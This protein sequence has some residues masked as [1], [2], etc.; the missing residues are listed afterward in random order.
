MRFPFFR[1]KSKVK[2][3]NE[4]KPNGNI[5]IICAYNEEKDIGA[6]LWLIHNTKLPLQIIVIDDGSTDNT[7][8]IAEE[9]GA[10]VFRLEQNQGKTGAFFKGLK[11]ALKLN[12]KSIVFLDAD[13]TEIPTKSL[14][15]LID[16]ASYYSEK[17]ISKMLVPL[18]Y[19]GDS[20]HPTAG[21]FTGIRAFSIPAAWKVLKSRFKY[22]P[23]RFALEVFLTD[24]FKYE[25][26]DLGI[27]FR[28]E[29]AFRKPV[30]V[31]Q[32]IDIGEY[33]T[34]LNHTKRPRPL[35]AHVSG[36]IPLRRF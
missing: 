16:E 33:Y 11:E 35:R 6:T 24:L 21:K 10:R 28:T 22:I 32:G 20:K 13:M 23:R 9:N 7:A 17:R 8:K 15:R 14:Y 36:R 27:P 29:R 26:E 19:E 25:K 31:Q 30:S 3:S 18:Q 12:P 34:K 4:L 2:I 5:V 1:K